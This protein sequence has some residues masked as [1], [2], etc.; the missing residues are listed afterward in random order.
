MPSVRQLA[1]QLAVNQNTVLKVYGQLCQEKVLTSERGNGTFVAAGANEVTVAE[2]R[3]VVGGLLGEAAA[4]GMQLG[5]GRAELRRLLDEQC[6]IV[7][8]ERHKERGR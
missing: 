2:R 3:R 7:D 5:L 6:D 8:N 1:H 4:R